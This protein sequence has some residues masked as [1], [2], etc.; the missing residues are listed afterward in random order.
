MGKWDLQ[1]ECE[2]IGEAC[3]SLLKGGALIV[4]EAIVDDQSS[5]ILRAEALDL[6]KEVKAVGEAEHRPIYL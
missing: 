3:A 6:V 5:E 1:E 2:L 4:Y